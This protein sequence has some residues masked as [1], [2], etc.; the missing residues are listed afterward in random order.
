MSFSTYFQPRGEFHHLFCLDI[1][2]PVHS[3]NTIA[4]GQNTSRLLQVC[5]GVSSHDLLLQDWRHLGCA[6]ERDDVHVTESCNARVKTHEWIHIILELSQINS[7][8]IKNKSEGMCDE[9]ACPIILDKYVNMYNALCSFETA[10]AK[11]SSGQQYDQYTLLMT[12][13]CWP[14]VWRTKFHIMFFSPVFCSH[15]LCVWRWLTPTQAAGTALDTWFNDRR[16]WLNVHCQLK[17]TKQIAATV[18][19]MHFKSSGSAALNCRRQ[20][21]SGFLTFKAW[22]NEPLAGS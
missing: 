19:N 9:I 16:I 21:L 5:R 7:I 10:I 14:I 15:G 11:T 13:G 17:F 22:L 2:Q 18:I 1:P 20:A 12:F 8:Q 3:G 6:C 4:N